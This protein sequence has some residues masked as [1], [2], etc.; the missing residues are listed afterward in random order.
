MVK[1]S[2][3]D[4]K[5]IE[6]DWVDDDRTHCGPAHQCIVTG[7]PCFPLM[8]SKMSVKQLHKCKWCGCTMATNRPVRSS[9]VV[10][11][12]MD[13]LWVP[14]DIMVGKHDE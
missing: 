3:L 10:E 8:V 14:R 13:R 4:S 5:L 9:G 12:G 2:L 7:E 11:C 6:Q 1:I